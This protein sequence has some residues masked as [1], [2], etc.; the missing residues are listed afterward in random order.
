MKKKYRLTRPKF[1]DRHL[2]PQ[3]LWAVAELWRGGP[4]ISGFLKSGV[5]ELNTEI[6]GFARHD[7]TALRAAISS[8]SPDLVFDS[9]N[10][11][12]LIVRGRFTDLVQPATLAPWLEPLLCPACSG[13]FLV[14][15]IRV[16]DSAP[17]AGHPPKTTQTLALG[18]T[19]DQ[20]KFLLKAS[21]HLGNLP[22]AEHIGRSAPWEHEAALLRAVDAFLST[23]SRHPAASPGS[24]QFDAA[25][26]D[27][28]LA[29]WHVAGAIGPTF[30]SRPK[31]HLSDF[32]ARYI[33]EF[34]DDHSPVAFVR[35]CVIPLLL[36]LT[37]G[38]FW[39]NLPAGVSFRPFLT[40]LAAL[41]IY[42]LGRV[43]YLKGKR[44]ISFHRAMNRGLRDLYAHD[45]SVDKIPLEPAF[46]SNPTCRKY[47]AEIQAI[48]AK[49]C[50]DF[51]ITAK[52][53]HQSAQRLFYLP[54]QNAYV[55]LSIMT[56]TGSFDQWPA[57]IIWHISTP[58]EDGTRLATTNTAGY[59]KQRMPK[60]LG[61]AHS[62]ID[63]PAE[64]LALHTAHVRRLIEKGNV[65]KVVDPD[66][67]PAM[68]RSEYEEARTFYAR[69]VIY[70]WSDALHQAFE[71]VRKN[72]D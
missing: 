3:H 8:A 13:L 67:Y 60:S 68:V 30:L 63:D 6:W 29:A 42:L 52:S 40:A 23:F 36:L 55:T 4:S 11:D 47:S 24:P 70:T 61:R 48:G 20:G 19:P 72:K 16:C 65:P 39:L 9:D 18:G 44:I 32:I 71:I 54:D 26:T 25:I 1:T 66:D 14:L 10:P 17:S 56:R 41:G 58:F 53:K 37:G 69:R 22:I 45:I 21:W 62:G 34:P 35:R 64:L 31:E 28:Q 12:F 51:R 49:H 7:T 5:Y 15:R 59:K 33:A 50:Y 2:D 46:E 27:A 38:Y 57:L 43:F